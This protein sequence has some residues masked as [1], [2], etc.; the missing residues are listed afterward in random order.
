MKKKLNIFLA[1]VCAMT[2]LF[3]STLCFAAENN[4]EMDNV[5]TDENSNNGRAARSMKGSEPK[6]INVGNTGVVAHIRLDYEYDS[7]YTGWFTGAYLTGTFVP[8]GRTV[9]YKGLSTSGTGNGSYIT[10]TVHYLINT[11]PYNVS[12]TF[13]VNEWGEVS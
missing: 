12:A 6:T 1:V 9:E 5:I 2:M 8:Q 13:Y 7:G 4:A 11:I 10:V 3:G